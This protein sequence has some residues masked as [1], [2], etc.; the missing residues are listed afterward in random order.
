[1]SSRKLDAFFYQLLVE[2]ENLLLPNIKESHFERLS[3]LMTLGFKVHPRYIKSSDLNEIENFLISLNEER[4][5]FNFDT[6]GAVIKVN[7]ISLR[8]QIGYT[9]K[10]PKWATA[11]KFETERAETK[12]LNVIFQVGR[13]GTI[14]PVAILEP[15]ELCQ[16]TVRRATLHNA[17]QLALLDVRIGDTV[18]VE[19]G[20]EIIPK[21]IGVNLEKRQ[22]NSTPIKMTATCPECGSLVIKDGDNV[23]YK[24][25]NANCNASLLGN[26]VHFASKECMNIDQLGP[27]K[28]Q[29]FV[30]HGLISTFSDI[31]K[32]K[33]SDLMKLER[34]GVSSANN[35]IK[36]IEKSKENS[37]ARVLYSLGI[38]KT[39]ETRVNK[40]A[41][42]FK[43]IEN[44]LNADVSDIMCMEDFGEIIA[45]SI[46]SYLSEIKDEIFKLQNLG[47]C[48]T[49]E[50]LETSSS[51]LEGK[52]FCITGTL[53]KPRPEFK[54]IIEDNG[55]EFHKDPKRT[56]NFILVG[57]E[58]GGGTL[59]S[60]TKYSIPLINESEFNELLK[61]SNPVKE[62]VVN[63]HYSI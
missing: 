38:P 24:C 57:T 41:Q 36:A 40:L 5:S 6:D 62:K 27:A 12:L 16:T 35:L 2:D 13:T 33:L 61:S 51:S 29:Q 34:M 11:F 32:L 52:S 10:T 58:P 44:L 28:I 3:F 9:S 43:T 55:G 19:K 50:E 1:V 49:Y 47:L 21:I 7:S 63:T 23:A 26:L 54:K 39:G 46:V 14:T 30:E 53:S 37:F 22:P 20:G 48:F 59:G 45:E 17:D 8:E 25:S 4:K 60:A 31:Y 42:K 56:T 15:V 18:Y